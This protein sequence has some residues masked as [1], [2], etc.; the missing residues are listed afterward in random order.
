MRAVA[1]LGCPACSRLA[2]SA[3]TARAR[4]GSDSEAEIAAALGGDRTRSRRSLEA[5][6]D[7]AAE[8]SV[9]V[10]RWADGRH[11]SWESP[12]TASRRHP[13]PFH[14]ALRRSPAQ[15]R[16]ARRA[17]RGAAYR[18]G[19]RLRRRALRRVLRE[20]RRAPSST[21]SRRASTTA[22]TGRSRAR[23]R[24]NSN[25]RSARSA[26]CRSARRSWSAPALRWR[27]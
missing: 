3:T 21:R 13:P 11:G 20:Q 2:A 7:F 12:R 22:A 15:R 8:F 17:R 9:I 24:R 25:S 6:V 23:P 27:I 14:R 16:S 4:R 26:A 19:A 5:A 10:A 1:E 18:R